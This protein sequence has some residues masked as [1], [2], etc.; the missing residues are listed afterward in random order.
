MIKKLYLIVFIISPLVLSGCLPKIGGGEKKAEA[1]QFVQGSVVPSFPQTV[2]LYKD[3]KT[4][5]SFESMDSWGASFVTEEDLNKV[6]EFYGTSLPALGWEADLKKNASYFTYNIKNEQYVGTI[7]INKASDGKRT[8]I[9]A[10]LT[11]R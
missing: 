1:D 8:A 4:V 9:L 11:T 3:A 7:V 6:V 5:E 10:S 2:P